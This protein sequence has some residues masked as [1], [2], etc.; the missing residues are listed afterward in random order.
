MLCTV[1]CPWGG[2]AG[3]VGPGTG[4]TQSDA[5]GQLVTGTRREPLIEPRLSGR[6]NTALVPE[7]GASL[8]FF[9]WGV[10]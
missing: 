9:G 7:I 6:I 10:P 5:G 3:L 8:T 4:A 2:S 1:R